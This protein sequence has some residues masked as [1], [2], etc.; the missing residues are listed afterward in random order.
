MRC[1]PIE[2]RV[3]VSIGLI[4][5]AI[6]RSEMSKRL[7]I[8]YSQGVLDLHSRDVFSAHAVTQSVS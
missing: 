5:G 2:K 1:S 6:E 4:L 3:G 7:W 8:W